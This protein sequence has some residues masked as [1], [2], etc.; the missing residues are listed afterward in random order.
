MTRI[1]AFDGEIGDLV[2]FSSS[3][4]EPISG[5]IES[6]HGNKVIL[7]NRGILKRDGTK[8]RLVGLFP[9]KYHNEVWFSVELTAWEEYE[10]VKR[11]NTPR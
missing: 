10:I 6:I 5:Y 2:E 4:V 3:D 9:E 11:Y 1:I 8:R 7:T